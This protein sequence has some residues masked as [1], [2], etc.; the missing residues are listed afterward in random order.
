MS[1][2]QILFALRDALNTVLADT[3]QPATPAPDLG[4]AEEPSNVT[5]LPTAAAPAEA[6]TLQ[7]LQRFLSETARQLGGP[8]VLGI[9]KNYTPD[10]QIGSLDDA[11]RASLWLEVEK[12][13]RAGG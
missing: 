6:P 8:A 5:K 12:R 7:Q 2:L 11:G 10:G 9:V 3:E 1:D 4:K 13:V